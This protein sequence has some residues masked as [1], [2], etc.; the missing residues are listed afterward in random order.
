MPDHPLECEAM[1]TPDSAVKLTDSA[2]EKIADPGLRD[3]KDLGNS[4]LLQ[5]TRGDDLLHL[6]HEVGTN[7]KMLCLF[8]P[9]SKVSEHVAG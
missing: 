7:Q 2:A 3:P 5:P 1:D 6:D 4:A 8:A 9:E